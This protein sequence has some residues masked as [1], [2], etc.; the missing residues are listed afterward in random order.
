MNF[1][2][3]GD[4]VL[5]SEVQEEKEI[6]GI[7]LPES[8]TRAYLHMQVVAVGD[9]RMPNGDGSYSRRKMCVAVGDNVMVQLNPMMMGSNQQKIGGVKYLAVNHH[10]IIAKVERGV[11]T[12]TLDT[13][14]PVGRWTLV[15]VDAPDKVGDIILPAQSPLRSAGEVKTYLAK[16]GEIAQK[17]LSDIPVGTR[18]MLEHSR[19]QPFALNRVPFAYVDCGSVSGALPDEMDPGV[20]LVLPS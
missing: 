12:L 3:F 7:A 14:H 17:E 19:V 6:N 9:G 15:R 1:H 20:K 13:F 18:V 2:I 16:L 5:L 10:D 11:F 4:R 8:R